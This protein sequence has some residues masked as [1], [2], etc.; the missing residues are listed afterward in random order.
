MQDTFFRRNLSK[1]KLP[2]DSMS[3]LLF[4]IDTDCAISFID[5]R[6][7]PKP[8]T[9]IWLRLPVRIKSLESCHLKMAI[10]PPLEESRPAPSD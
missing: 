4:R 10:R 7:Y 5:M 3:Q 6:S 1:K 9:A 2:G 8:A